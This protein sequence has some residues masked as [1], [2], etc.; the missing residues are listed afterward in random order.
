MTE[1]LAAVDEYNPPGYY[2]GNTGKVSEAGNGQKNAQ[3]EYSGSNQS[4]V[5]NHA[6]ISDEKEGKIA[7]LENK[8]T[9]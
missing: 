9:S 2:S 3:F 4:S 7:N 8:I 5:S 6:S 1:V